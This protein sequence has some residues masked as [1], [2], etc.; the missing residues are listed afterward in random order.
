[1]ISHIRDDQY[2]WELVIH[3]KFIGQVQRNINVG[4][5]VPF[6]ELQKRLVFNIS[7]YLHQIVMVMCASHCD[8]DVPTTCWPKYLKLSTKICD[9]LKLRWN[10]F[11]TVSAVL[12]WNIFSLVNTLHFLNISLSKNNNLQHNPNEQNTSRHGFWLYRV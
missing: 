3:C 9:H 4:F 1:M 2:W 11:Q 8:V 6:G 10:L 12:Y 7:L 5:L